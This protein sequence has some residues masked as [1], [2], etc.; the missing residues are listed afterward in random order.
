MSSTRLARLVASVA[1]MSAP[2][3]LLGQ[4]S[5]ASGAAFE[6]RVPSGHFIGTGDQRGQL[7]NANATAVQLSWLV[8]P[9]LALT[10]TFSWA[11]SRD[12]ATST[13]PKLDVFTSDL[14]LELRTAT[15][16]GP[17]RLDLSGF[18]GAGAGARSYNH[19]SLDV[20]ATH[21]LAG[22]A[23]VGG[24]ARLGRVGM[25]LEARDYASGFKSLAGRGTSALRNDMVV[26][27]AITLHSGRGADR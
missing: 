14:G 20:A 21:N 11:R 10:G 7:K 8:R 1:V 17:A 16:R 26:M 22:Y 13:A 4:S 27:A 12:L 9:R 23:A 19:R 24:E 5:P 3:S 6:V 25:R 2:V 18:A 15:R